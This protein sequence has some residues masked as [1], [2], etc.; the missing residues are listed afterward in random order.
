MEYDFYPQPTDAAKH[1]GH[2]ERREALID[3]VQKLPAL[4]VPRSSKLLSE[5]LPRL[6]NIAS[7]EDAEMEDLPLEYQQE[8]LDSMASALTAEFLLSISGPGDEYP[9]LAVLEV[10]LRG[11]AMEPGRSREVAVSAFRDMLT[12]MNAEAVKHVMLTSLCRLADN[13]GSFKSRQSASELLGDVY[14]AVGDNTEAKETIRNVTIALSKDV[15]TAVVVSVSRSLTVCLDRGI[16]AD[17][18]DSFILPVY[19]EFKKDEHPHVR[20]GACDILLSLVARGGRFRDIASSGLNAC[21][22]DRHCSVIGTYVLTV[23]SLFLV[24][25]IPQFYDALGPDLA[26][27]KGLAH[28]LNRLLGDVNLLVRQK[29]LE[30]LKE[31]MESMEREIFIEFVAPTFMSLARDLFS[32]VRLALAQN[33]EAIWAY[34]NDVNFNMTIDPVLIVMLSALLQDSE[35]TQVLL[36]TLDNLL[37]ETIV[38]DIPID[39][40]LHH[41]LEA[42]IARALGQ[43]MD[44]K[45]K[46]WRF[47]QFALD[48]VPDLVSTY[49]T[50]GDE[51]PL[52]GVLRSMVSALHDPVW[53]VRMSATDNI[54]KFMSAISTK[55][56]YPAVKTK[57]ME[58]IVVTVRNS[59]SHAARTAALMV[60]NVSVSQ[61][62]NRDLSDVAR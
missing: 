17:E 26:T 61:F 46:Q 6:M 19:E 14:L 24:F 54:P 16:S 38:K 30:I 60:L 44:L 15:M 41:K 34:M 39:S 55:A 49:F 23:I 52:I 50:S 28:L 8:V 32:Q 7:R 10:L 1:A 42:Y 48:M 35:S 21:I 45:D 31:T 25:S 18:I 36:C 27:R 43:I 58:A 57:A 40:T 51:V 56:C 11:I 37:S 59:S 4:E 12:K 2:L 33:I 3:Y 20:S 9:M 53:S 62:K 22:Q 5:H 47:R 13:R 29:S